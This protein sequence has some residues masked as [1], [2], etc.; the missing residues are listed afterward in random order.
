MTEKALKSPM[1][2]LNFLK[3]TAI[4]AA[5]FLCFTTAQADEARI[6]FVSTERIFREANPAKAA[7]TKISQEF[8]KREKELQE[9]S[10]RLKTTAEKLDRDAAV[11]TESDRIKRQRELADLDKD[12]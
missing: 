4:T 10:A 2:V 1:N 7:Q 12:F 11:I 9:L 5:S 8:A 6:G 3:C